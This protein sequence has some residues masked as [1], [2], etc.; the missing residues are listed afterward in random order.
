[1]PEAPVARGD[2][3]AEVGDVAAGAVRV[4][5]DRE[6]ADDGAVVVGD[7]DGR[8]GVAAKRAQVAPLLAD[9]APAVRVQQPRL[10][11]AA[12]R[13]A[14]RDERRRVLRPRLADHRRSSDDDA[15]AAAAR[16]AGGGERAVRAALDRGDAAEVEVAA[17]PAHRP[18]SPRARRPSARP[19]GGARRPRRAGADGR[20]PRRRACRAGPRRRPG[21]SRRPAAPSRRCRARAAG[22]RP[23]ARASASSCSAAARPAPSGA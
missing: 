4:A 19:R 17:R 2:H 10:G 7:V 1:M 12:D 22:G 15:V 13:G 11:L 9:G 16:V 3:Q 5:G 18:S 20:S 8:V 21:R 23:R 6:A 14:E